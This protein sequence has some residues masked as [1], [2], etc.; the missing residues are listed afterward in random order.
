MCSKLT[1]KTPKRRQ[2]RRFSVLIVN[3]EQVSYLCPSISIVNFEHVIADWDVPRKKLMGQSEEIKQ[4]RTRT[5]NYHICFYV[6]FS[7]YDQYL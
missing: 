2:W 5:R 3:F 7:S 4:N 1:I 6:I